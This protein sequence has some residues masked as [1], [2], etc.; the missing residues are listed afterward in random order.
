M[1]KGE[2]IMETRKNNS[3]I[4]KLAKKKVMRFL[5]KNI[6][7]SVFVDL[8]YNCENA[9]EHV[10]SLYNAIDGTNFTD[11]KIVKKIKLNG[12]FYKRYI[13]DVS[14]EING[15][16]LVLAEHQSTLN[17]NMPLRFLLYV[18]RLYEKILK[19]QNRYQEKMI[20]LPTPKFYVFYNGEKP[21]NDLNLSEAFMEPKASML[22]LNVKVFN[23]NLNEGSD[24]LAKCDILKEYSILMDTVTRFK[25]SGSE[26][27]YKEAINDCIANGILVEYLEENR[28][29]VI[30]MLMAEYSYEEDIAVKQNEIR[31]EYEEKLREKDEEIR[32]LRELVESL[33]NK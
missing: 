33:S 29:E 31:D 15:Q 1:R 30:N 19:K 3:K 28:S 26:D 25:K 18:A 17:N 2:T 12:V 11:T 8:F 21:V 16:V 13:N 6:K 32:R 9:K 7:D 22:Q 5:N 10:L 4:I 20:K 14:F 24:L 27:P 23:I